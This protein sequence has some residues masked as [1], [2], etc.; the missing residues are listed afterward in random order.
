VQREAERNK[1]QWGLWMEMRPIT[2][3]FLQHAVVLRV[4][5]DRIAFED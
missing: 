5:P 3:P 1:L 4:L 2:T